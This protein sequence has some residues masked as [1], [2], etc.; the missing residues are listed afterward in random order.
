MSI[1]EKGMSILQEKFGNNKDNVLGLATIALEPG[2]E[3]KPRPIV[4]DVDAFY[5]DGVFY[6]VTH[7]KSQKMLQIAQ[8]NEVAIAV[9][10]EWF[11]A[12]GLGENL[13]WA[14]DPK[15]AEL[16]TKLRTVFSE[17][18]DFA[19]NENDENC[20]YLAIRLTNGIINVNHHE[21]LIYMDF[22]I[23]TATLK[24]KEI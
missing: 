23:Q 21:T 22:T 3:G 1:Y 4:R 8:N 5:E 2:T 20:C 7:A 10:F 12:S 17:W 24:G 9:N 6:V 18:Y 15:N 14:L 16:R 19:N 11:T 13:G